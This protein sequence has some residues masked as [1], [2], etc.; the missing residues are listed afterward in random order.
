VRLIL[1]IED[2]RH[3][4]RVGEPHGRLIAASLPA[5]SREVLRAIRSGQPIGRNGLLWV[6]RRA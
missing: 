5:S 4:R 2:S 3:N 1:A 6:R